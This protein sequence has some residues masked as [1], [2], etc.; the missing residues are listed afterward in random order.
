MCL[1]KILYFK[2]IKEHNNGC[3]ITNRRVNFFW[4]YFIGQ[5]SDQRCCMV[6]KCW[7]VKNQH[8]NQVSVAEMRMLR[9]MGG[10]T[11]RDRITNDTIRECWGSTHS[12]KDGRK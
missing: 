9:W 11:R 4:G 2:I 3:Q 7:A 5:Q 1:L 8:K 6:M 10:K 12:R